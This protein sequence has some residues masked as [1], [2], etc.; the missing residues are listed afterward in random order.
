M[1]KIPGIFNPFESENKKETLRDVY[2]RSLPDTVH[3]AGTPPPYVEWQTAKCTLR[4][5]GIFSDMLLTQVVLA[6]KELYTLDSDYM[7]YQ[8]VLYYSPHN[9][10]KPSTGYSVVRSSEGEVHIYSAD[11]PNDRDS[12]AL[13]RWCNVALAMPESKKVFSKFKISVTFSL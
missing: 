12:A 5:T 3:E 10:P 4:V 7:R 9:I 6:T 2:D 8:G 11:L 13:S 1:E